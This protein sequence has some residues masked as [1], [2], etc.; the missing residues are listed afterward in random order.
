[1]KALGRTT[2][3]PADWAASVH[4]A[5]LLKRGDTSAPTCSSCHGSHGA[6]PPG[7][8]TVVNVCAQCHVREAQLF[9]AS[10]KKDIFDALGQGECVACH[11][12]HR[13]ESPSDTWLG[14]QEGA[15]C[16][17]CH[18][19]S[20]D[21]GTTIRSLR[22]HLDTLD[23]GIKAADATLARAEEA[24]MLVDDGRAALR[25]AHER[26]VQSRTLVHAFAPEPFTATATQ[27]ANAAQR[28][29]ETGEA[30]LRE[31]QFRR[32]GLGLATL[33]ILGFLIAL[34]IKIRGLPAGRP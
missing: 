12:N 33:V 27:G 8:T 20:G 28:A 10:P 24:G 29:Q 1:M 18:D 14:L 15:V 25:E 32:R 26:Q 7:V 23:A 9:R 16:A 2:A 13:I 11:S 31:L 19:D 30:A 4:A 5:A 21:S 22:Q 6:T 3:P 17:Q 34:G